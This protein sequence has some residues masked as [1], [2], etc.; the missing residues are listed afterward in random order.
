MKI[1]FFE[2][3]DWQKSFFKDCLKDYTLSFDSKPL[4]KENI[5]GAEDVEI[6]SGMVYSKFSKEIL[7]LFPNLRMITTRSTG[8]DHIDL[9]YCKL[10]NIAACNVPEYGSNTVA[11]HTF[12]LILA[13]SRKIIPSVERTKRG[14]FSLDGLRGFDLFGKT[15]GAIGVGHIAKAAIRIAKGFGMKVVVFSHHPDDDLARE[16]DFAW[17]DLPTLLS[18]SDIVSLHVPLTKE[19][20]HLINIENILHFKKGSLLINTSRGGVVQTEAILLGLEKGVLTGAGLDVLE[21]ECF[22]KEETQLLTEE[23][24]KQCDIK[25]QLLNHVLLTKKNVLVTPHN[26]F[27]SQEALQRILSTTAGNITS[28]LQGKTENRVV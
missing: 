3:E 10:K 21:E 17:V 5:G 16:L 9:E 28:F 14:D 24:L 22:I 23:F 18:S 2:I 6:L 19:T 12:A 8:F 7:S 26:A 20:Q 4:T 27:N 1:A 13:V 25:T 15:F 11:E